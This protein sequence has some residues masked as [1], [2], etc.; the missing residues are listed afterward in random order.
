[1]ITLEGISEKPAPLVELRFWMS[2]STMFA[3]VW[4]NLKRSVF[5]RILFSLFNLANVLSIYSSQSFSLESEVEDRFVKKVLKRLPIST[6]SSY[7]SS[8]CKKVF[9]V[10]S[11]VLL[12]FIFMNVDHDKFSWINWRFLSNLRRNCALKI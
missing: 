9:G 12:D 6:G 2:F 8:S 3:L 7:S 4:T 5:R 1:M 10:K 11:S